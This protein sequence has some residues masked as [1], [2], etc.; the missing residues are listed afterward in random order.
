MLTSACSGGATRSGASGTD[1]A[2]TAGSSTTAP[3]STSAPAI[4]TAPTTTPATTAVPTTAPT[5]TSVATTT[6]PTTTSVAAASPPS[7]ADL[8]QVAFAFESVADL[9]WPVG[10]ASRPGDPGLYVV[11]QLGQVWRIVDGEVQPDLVLDLRDRTAVEQPAASE[12][13]V[14][15][16]AFS[17]VDDRMVID[18]TDTDGHSRVASWVVTDGRADPDSEWQ[19]VTATQPGPGHNGGG[20]AF[21]PDGNLYIGFGD[22]G[23]SNG[24]DA[25]DLTN[26]LGTVIRVTPR[27]DGPGYDIPAD[28]PFVGQEGVL[29]EIYAFGLRNPWR[30][31]YD[32]PTGDIWL[33]DVGNDEIE[34][35]DRI[36]AGEKGLDFGWYH[37][38]GTRQ[39]RG[40]PPADAVPP[41]FEWGRDKGVAAVGG[42][43]Y[44][45]SLIGGLQGAYVFGDL[46]GRMWFQGA[47]GQVEHDID[48]AGLVAFGTDTADELYLVSIYGDVVRMV[49]A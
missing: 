46:T 8:E 41:V 24:T 1:G 35:I 44:R 25:R 14:L 43:V 9:E 34:E 49:P 28:N 21:D 32:V 33:G 30:L 5:T 31:T 6:A 18:Y 17:P 23:G 29:P 3:S 12:R 36:P 37:L 10:F 27:T 40:D 16:I 38:E 20:L 42:H 47:D 7:V 19:I 48:L 11:G 39:H 13:G 45:G 4:T 22:G 2:A 26:L 15:G